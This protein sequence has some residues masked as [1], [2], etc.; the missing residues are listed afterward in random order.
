MKALTRRE[1]S[2]E[3]LLLFGPHA[4]FADTLQKFVVEVA[5]RSGTARDGRCF[6]LKH[7]AAVL[8]NRL[9]RYSWREGVRNRG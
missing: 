5:L 6:H 4:S 8:Q 7:R 3:P 2:C 9:R 1:L